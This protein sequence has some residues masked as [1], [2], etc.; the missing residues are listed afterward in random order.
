MY[1]VDEL[2]S[3]VPKDKRDG[4]RLV[5][6]DGLT[7]SEILPVICDILC[8]TADMN[9]PVAEKCRDIVISHQN[10]AIPFIHGVLSG[11]I[12]LEHGED[13]EWQY[14]IITEIVPML[15]PE[16]RKI[17]KND[18]VRISECSEQEYSEAAKDSLKEYY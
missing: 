3:F 18:L 5:M 17:I 4:D 13:K 11:K 16:N 2:K 9:R 14:F 1:T 12:S 15:T 7:D 8:W 10:A 6:F